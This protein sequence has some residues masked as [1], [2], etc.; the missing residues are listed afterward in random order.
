MERDWHLLLFVL[1]QNL[2][3]M[4]DSF[5]ENLFDLLPEV[6]ESVTPPASTI[7]VTTDYPGEHGFQLHI[8]ASGVAKCVTSTVSSS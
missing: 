2:P 1:V 3:E 8:R 7:P 6:T 4:S 5:D